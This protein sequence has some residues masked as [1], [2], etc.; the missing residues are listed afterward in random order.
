MSSIH[1]LSSIAPLSQFDLFGVPPTQGSV[2]KTI[3]TEHRPLTAENNNYIEFVFPTGYDEYIDFS[4]L[5][6]SLIVNLSCKKGATDASEADWKNVSVINYLLNS[7]FQQVD[8]FINEKQITTSMTT[9]PYKAFFEALLGIGSDFKTSVLKNSFWIFDNDDYADSSLKKP[10]SER[11][12]YLPKNGGEIYLKGKLH[13]D[14]SFQGRFLLGGMNI[15]LRLLLNDPKFV[16]MVNDVNLSPKFHI[17]Q[18]RLEV[19]R[20]KVTQETLIGHHKALSIAPAKYPHIRS[21]VKAITIN[22]AT[23]STLIDNAISGLLPRRVV[24]GFVAN[25]SFLGNISKNPFYFHHY[26][27]NY[28]AW[29]R[30]GEQ[31]PSLAYQPDFESNKFIIEIDDL[32]S[33]FNQIEHGTNI[34]EINRLNYKN[35]LTLFATNFSQD[36]SDG[37]AGHF[38]PISR[39]SMSL[40]IHFK[41]ALSETINCLIFSE[42]DSIL[43]VPADR[44]PE[45]VVY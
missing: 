27:I 22:K 34:T 37:T 30:D 40:E 33:A 18:A 17:K 10:S 7:L 32:F 36:N 44:N 23:H 19:S 35:G 20:A 38:N 2:V 21:E 8:L 25:D 5:K 9:Y 28:F 42:Y 4:Q 31:F 39:G 26:K 13:L 15:K 14:L 1:P 16:F 6:L 43:E 24:V 45:S 3:K 29:K 41:E 12:K 11:Q